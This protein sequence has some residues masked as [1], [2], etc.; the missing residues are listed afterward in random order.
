MYSGW[1]TYGNNA[2]EKMSLND[3]KNTFL[4]LNTKQRSFDDWN[5]PTK[6]GI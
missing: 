3:W 5:K 1:K 2:Y 6:E 4:K